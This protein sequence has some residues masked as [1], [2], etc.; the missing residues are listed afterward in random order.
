MYL[1]VTFNE[2]AQWTRITRQQQFDTPEIY[3]QIKWFV[4]N[5]NEENL[6][7][8]DILLKQHN[9]FF[10]RLG[11]SPSSIY[12]LDFLLIVYYDNNQSSC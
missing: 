6:D 1:T 7:R 4:S 2:E 9:S 3:N 12:D 11:I 10:E 8:L 5:A